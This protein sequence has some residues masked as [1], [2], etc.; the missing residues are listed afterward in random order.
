MT[1]TRR[2]SIRRPGRI[3]SI[4][5]TVLA[6]ATALGAL[7]ALLFV[8]E[9]Q[10]QP[11]DD[12]FTAIAVEPRAEAVDALAADAGAQ[13][14]RAVEQGDD[15]LLLEVGDASATA[16][17]ASLACDVGMTDL[18][19]AGQRSETVEVAETALARLV[20]LPARATVDP[21]APLQRIAAHLAASEVGTTAE[22]EIFLNLA[23]WNPGPSVS[24][25][26]DAP[27][28]AELVAAA[29]ADARLPES[30]EGWNV[31]VI[32]PGTGDPAGDRGREQ[33]VTALLDACGGSLASISS[34]WVDDG[35]APPPPQGLRP[36]QRA[37]RVTFA[38]GDTL[39]ELGR[40]NLADAAATAI[41][42]IV[43]IVEA[44]I[45]EG[46]RVRVHVDGYASDDGPDDVNEQLS[47]ERAQAVGDEIMARVGLPDKAIVVDGHGSLPDDGTEAQRR[48][49]RRVDVTIIGSGVDDEAR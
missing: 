13:L 20:D 26:A 9:D 35:L 11:Q 38:L 45:D 33:F 46:R 6:A 10:R 2:A 27:V 31:H 22:V 30:C 17:H 14:D 12:R 40:A 29:Q 5:R 28:P 48:R 34:R 23:G 44:E 43:E 42:E 3:G 7:G 41:N 47:Y 32:V 21:L 1:A 49:N 37:G 36:E 19:C 24:W 25:G 18:R 16:Q 39:F 8:L 4:A 15:L